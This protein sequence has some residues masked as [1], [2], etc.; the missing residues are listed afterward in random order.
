MQFLSN[1]CSKVCCLLER[2][3]YYTQH[4]T[5]KNL[6]TYYEKN[7]WTLDKTK[8]LSTKLKL[9]K[10]SKKGSK[11]SKKENAVR[12]YLWPLWD[13]RNCILFPKIFWMLEKNVFAT[14]FKITRTIYWNSER[15]NRIFLWLSYGG[16]YSSN[17][18]EQ[19]HTY[20]PIG[21][22]NW[23]VITCRNKF[24][25]KLWSWKAFLCDFK[26]QC[27]VCGMPGKLVTLIL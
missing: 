14:F 2:E 27:N 15:S 24:E 11:R 10:F 9:Y 22:N 8:I 17:T 23:V 1:C 25:K 5:F 16:L 18:L 19:V 3:L 4:Q 26:T 21:S 7:P 12:K 13:R 20:L 6:R